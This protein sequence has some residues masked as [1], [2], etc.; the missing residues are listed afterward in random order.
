MPYVTYYWQFEWFWI[1]WNSVLVS[2]DI[3]NMFSSTDN[4]L[5]I[6]TS[7]KVLSNRE[8]KNLPTECVLEALKLCLECNNSL[9]NDKKV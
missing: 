4:E 3:V 8:S 7:K 2:F 6:N 5:G 9:F 1:A